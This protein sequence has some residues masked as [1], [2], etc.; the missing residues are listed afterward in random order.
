MSKVRLTSAVAPPQHLTFSFEYFDTTKPKFGFAHC[1]GHYFADVFDRL[2]ALSA[3]TRNEFVSMPA[4]GGRNWRV[5]QIDWRDPAVTE[6]T[7]GVP[8]QLTADDS[9][10]QFNVSLNRGRV[11]GFLIGSVFFVRWLDP[12][13]ALY[14]NCR[15]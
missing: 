10:W 2:K 8:V 1:D 4:T 11:H 9:A 3:K 13:H 6:R 5:H 14:G 7:F 12:N 15:E